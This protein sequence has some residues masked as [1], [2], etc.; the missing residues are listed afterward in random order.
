[1]SRVSH[2]VEHWCSFYTR[3]LPDTVAADR[4][5]ELTSDLFEHRAAGGSTASIA[6][7]WIAGIPSDLSWRYRMLEASGARGLR[8][9]TTAQV[10]AAL[11]VAWGITVM[12]RFAT[13]TAQYFELSTF[14]LLAAAT[15]IAAIGLAMFSRSNQRVVGVV[16]LTIAALA[17]NNL[18]LKVGLWISWTWTGRLQRYV[19]IHLMPMPLPVALVLIYLPG[20]LVTALFVIAAVRSRRVGPTTA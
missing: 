9:F 18:T 10:L 16:A 6:R 4:R 5:E 14:L 7:R 2:L 15:G 19:L 11:M 20:L 3:D 13:S 17:F 12:I 1:M 8:L